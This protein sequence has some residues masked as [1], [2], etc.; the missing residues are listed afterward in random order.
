MSALPDIGDRDTDLHTTMLTVLIVDDE[1][2]L[3]QA[4]SAVLEDTAFVVLTATSA[5]DGIKELERQPIDI[6]ISDYRMPN[7]DGVDFLAHVATVQ[8]KAS[9]VLMTAFAD[10]STTLRAINDAHI[11]HLLHK[12][13]TGE[14][15]LGVLMNLRQT[16]LLRRENERLEEQ[17]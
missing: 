1:S 3:L 17:V 10:L 11:E 7:I 12:P 2:F 16:I 14:Q 6:V 8:P 5:D 15:L 9:R 13:I 4:L